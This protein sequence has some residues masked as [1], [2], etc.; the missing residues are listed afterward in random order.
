M[1]LPFLQSNRLLAIVGLLNFLCYILKK[2]KKYFFSILNYSGSH[3]SILDYLSESIFSLIILFRVIKISFLKSDFLYPLQTKHLGCDTWNKFLRCCLLYA[4]L[5]ILPKH[6]VHKDI[7][8]LSL[9]HSRILKP[10][11]LA[12]NV[13]SSANQNRDHG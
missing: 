11:C 5:E 12:S 6:Q 4:S 8:L 1:W 9:G 7:K 2:R 13:S 3:T 10:Q